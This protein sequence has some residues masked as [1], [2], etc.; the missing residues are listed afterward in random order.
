REGKQGKYLEIEGTPDWIMEIV[1]DSSVRKDKTRLREAYHR[2]GIPEY[3]LIDARGE[4]I[5]FQ[6][7]LWRRNGYAAA[8]QRG[9][10]QPSRVFRHGFRLKRQRDELGFWEYT[11]HAQ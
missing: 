9:G 1:S 2:V 10:W 8:P 3:W 4:E 6:I 11:L 5:S 7:L